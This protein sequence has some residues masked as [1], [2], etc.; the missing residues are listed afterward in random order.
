[1]LKQVNKIDY[2]IVRPLGILSEKDNITTELN[3]ISYNN[4]KPKLDLRKWEKKGDNKILQRGLTLTDEEVK[5][6]FNAL[7]EYLEHKEA[8]K[9]VK[10]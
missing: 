7:K 5:E 9:E 2:R 4:Y 1:M 6:L 3:L 10:E 8:S